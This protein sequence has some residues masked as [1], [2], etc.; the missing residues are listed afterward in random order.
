MAGERTEDLETG[1]PRSAGE[2]RG[3]WRSAALPG[4]K[5][6]RSGAVPGSA[7]SHRR[8]YVQVMPQA[9]LP[10]LTVISDVVANE[11]QNQ[12]HVVEDQRGT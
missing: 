8:D 7:R 9:S 12:L 10:A 4:C 6:C 1:P 5:Q 11:G 2:R 3:R